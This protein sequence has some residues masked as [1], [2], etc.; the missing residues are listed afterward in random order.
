MRQ[1]ARRVLGA[2]ERVESN[3]RRAQRGAR[4][5]APRRIRLAVAALASARACRAGPRP[6]LPAHLAV[7]APRTLWVVHGCTPLSLSLACSRAARR[8]RA[9][10]GSPGPGAYFKADALGTSGMGKQVVSTKP[11]SAACRF[12]TATREAYA[13]TYM[14]KEISSRVPSSLTAKAEFLRQD[15]ATI[16]AKGPDSR[17]ETTPK[18]SFGKASRDAYTK[19]YISPGHQKLLPVTVTAGVEFRKPVEGLGKAAPESTR[20]SSPKYSACSPVDQEERGKRREGR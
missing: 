19:T 7:I 15:Y 17:H 12:G 5:R 13:K 8:P 16:G 20:P 9:R 1:C 2:S 14:D 18:F 6:L 10:P 11:S 4:A 3:R